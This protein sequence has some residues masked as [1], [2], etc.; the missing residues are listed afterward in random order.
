MLFYN[1]YSTIYFLKL[2]S[3]GELRFYSNIPAV[4][5]LHCSWFDITSQLEF[6]QLLFGSWPSILRM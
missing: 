4:S 1:K 6:Q 5:S 2:T 3:T